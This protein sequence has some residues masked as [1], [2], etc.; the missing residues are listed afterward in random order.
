[1]VTAFALSA[2][3][4]L[5]LESLKYGT[6]QWVINWSR[7]FRTAFAIGNRFA[8]D[9]E[10]VA[11][12]DLALAHELCERELDRSGLEKIEAEFRV[13]EPIGDAAAAR[14]LSTT[15]YSV[16]DRDGMA[17]SNTYSINTLFGSKLVVD[18]AGFFLNNT[19]ADFR[20]GSGPNWYG[21]LQGDNN[22]LAGK[23]RPASSMAPA[24]VVQEG[25]VTMAIGGSG[26]PRI[27][28]SVAQVISAVFAEGVALSDAVSRRRVHHQLFPDDLVIEKGF[29]TST[30][31]RLSKD[32]HP[33]FVVSSLST[34]AAIRRRLED[35]EIAAVLDQR[36]GDFW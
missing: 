6:P 27:P 15:H 3:Q 19:M 20:I 31:D 23:R 24:I 13:R 4:A 12:A 5:E 32:G 11:P 17:V 16:M 33:I 10:V 9:P 26:G 21:L 25:S 22:R 28:T 14:R 18:G 8:G 35:D 2:A 36:F 29:Q 30:I 7:V 1:M 34:V